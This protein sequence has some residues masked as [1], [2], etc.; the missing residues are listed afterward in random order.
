MLWEGGESV[1]GASLRW[2][3]HQR[4]RQLR[5]R[6][7]D[8]GTVGEHVGELEDVSEGWCACQIVRQGVVSVFR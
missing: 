4:W 3:L 8:G 1:G 5:E 6:M 2:R 7:A